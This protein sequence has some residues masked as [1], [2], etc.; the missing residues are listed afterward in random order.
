MAVAEVEKAVMMVAELE[1]AGMMVV[2][3]L[4]HAS[5]KLITEMYI[6][7]TKSIL[8]HNEFKYNSHYRN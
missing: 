4:F 5:V 1:K 7:N 6:V 8:N 3:M 2:V